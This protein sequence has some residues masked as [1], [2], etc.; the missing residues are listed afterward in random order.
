MAYRVGRGAPGSL[1][2]LEAATFPR[3]LMPPVWTCSLEHPVSGG[4]DARGAQQPCKGGGHLRLP[5]HPPHSATEP[6]NLLTRVRA[7]HMRACVSARVCVC[8]PGAGP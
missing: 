5:T 2:P 7:E 1:W 8:L 4:G 3:A 6:E